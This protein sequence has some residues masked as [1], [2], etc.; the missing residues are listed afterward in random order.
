MRWLIIEDSLENLNGHWYA[1]IRGFHQELPRLGDELVLLCSRRAEPYILKNLDARPVLPESLPLRTSRVGTAKRTWKTL[2]YVLKSCSAISRQA[3]STSAFDWIFVPD[4]TLYHLLVWVCLIKTVLRYKRP[5]ILLLFLGLPV[6]QKAGE[7][8]VINGSTTSKTFRRLL[9][10]IASDVAA[11]KVILGVESQT[12]KE[13]GETAFGVPF[14]YIPQNIPHS[15][16]VLPILQPAGSGY[17]T[18]ACYGPA[19]HEKGSDILVAAIKL[20]LERFPDS[21]TCFVFQWMEDFDAPKGV[22]ARI[23]DMLFNHPR[24]EIIRQLLPPDLMIRHLAATQVLLLPYRESSYGLRGSRVVVEAMVHGLPMITTE[25]TTLHRQMQEHGAGLVCKD[26]DAESLAAG[27]REMELRYAEFKKKA[28][29]RQPAAVDHFSIQ[30]CREMLLT[31]CL[32]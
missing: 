15:C 22:P 16:E 31:Q 32:S 29:E 18:M 21:P 17:I 26:G 10:L 12:M 20:Y 4:V 6:Q 25:G 13:A 23:P 19:R 3:G 7:G 8:A 2:D 30:T 24:V 11:Q 1:H 14:V 27:I 5:R 28:C 9:R